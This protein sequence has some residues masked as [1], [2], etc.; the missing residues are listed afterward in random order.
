VTPDSGAR[1]VSRTGKVRTYT[2][3]IH[4]P[5]PARRHQRVH[6]GTGAP[7]GSPGPPF[8]PLRGLGRCPTAKG[9]GRSGRGRTPVLPPPRASCR[10][11]NG[12]RRHSGAPD[13]ALPAA[14]C[15]QSDGRRRLARSRRGLHD[16][17]RGNCLDNVTFRQRAFRS[18]G[19]HTRVRQAIH[20]LTCRRAGMW[21]SAALR[22]PLVE[23][24]HCQGSL[25]PPNRRV[26][27]GPF[28]PRALGLPRP[29]G[30]GS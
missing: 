13:R 14:C 10:R 30:S 2:S 8:I 23:W 15:R 22:A 27:L 12:Y 21:G 19:W 25:R 18:P 29:G 6:G 4:G 17:E 7:G 9:A 26:A 24:S 3:A 28:P 11:P 5:S 20:P 16:T 1:S